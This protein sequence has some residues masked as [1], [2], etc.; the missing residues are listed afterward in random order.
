MRE[1]VLDEVV[2]RRFL[3]GQLSSEEQGRI[4]ELA[5]E[6]RDTFA[7]LES[8]EDDLLDEFIQGELS[9][10]EKQ[11]F[12]N[13]FL[14]FAGRNNNLK[15]SRI[16]QQHLDQTDQELSWISRFNHQPI[17]VRA[18][19]TVLV[20][21]LVIIVAVSIFIRVREAT[22]PTPIQA[23]PDKPVVAPSRE[24]KISPSLE[25]TSSPAH[26]EN[27]PK[28]LT[29]EKQKAVPA[30]AVLSPSALTRGD[31]VQQLKLPTYVSSVPI[32][33]ALITRRSFRSY[34]AVLENEA[35]AVLKQW[36][37][38]EAEN[39]TFGKALKIDVPVRLLEPQKFYRIVVSGTSL[40]GET[41]VIARYPFEAIK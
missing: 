8:V 7:F 31:G 39:L 29:P 25:P 5:F 24:F 11:Q 13:H 19:L 34:E 36:S 10:E 37:N 2:A 30:Y 17:W 32:E 38:L 41:E 35:G 3:L 28:N 27:K 33:L 21:A 16:L 15:F 22:R 12:E 1:Q 18:S 9:A 14:T 23:G 26:V 20:V 40:K 4:Q 6:D